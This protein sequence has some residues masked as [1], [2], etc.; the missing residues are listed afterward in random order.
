MKFF[1]NKYLK[2]NY[3]HQLIVVTSN[4][5]RMK[6][7]SI[8]FVPLIEQN[9]LVILFYLYLASILFSNSIEICLIR[10]IL[11]QLKIKEISKKKKLN[12][13]RNYLFLHSLFD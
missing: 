4:Q 12:Y 1:K 8:V 5:T 10:Q 2:I 11:N 9:D 7:N 3:H 13:Y 6:L